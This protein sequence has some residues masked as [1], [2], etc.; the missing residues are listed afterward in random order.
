MHCV[1][2]LGNANSTSD[3]LQHHHE[4]VRS[5]PRRKHLWRRASFWKSPLL[6]PERLS[7]MINVA[8]GAGGSGGG[9]ISA[10]T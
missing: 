3:R 10:A 1:V 5:A 4:L 9:A 2:S 6:S 7:V 8:G